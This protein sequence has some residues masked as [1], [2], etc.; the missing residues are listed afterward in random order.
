MAT[1]I[2]VMVDEARNAA[3]MR[4]VHNVAGL[5]YSEQIAGPD[6]LFLVHAFP[7]ISDYFPDNFAHVLNHHLICHYGFLSKE[8]PVVDI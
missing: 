3:F 6:S 2:T 7:D 8:A 4:S 1:Y 5:I